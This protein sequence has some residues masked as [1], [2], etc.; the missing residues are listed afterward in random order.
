MAKDSGFKVY[1]AG[2]MRGYPLYNFPA[3]DEA[4][5]RFRALHWDVVNPAELD[6][7]IGVN[8]YTDPLPDGFLRGAMER[9]LT[10]ICGC[11]AIALLPGWERSSGVAVE[12]ALAKLLG[13][14][15]YDAATGKPYSET[16]VQEAQRLVHGDRGDSYG[17]PLDDYTKTAALWSVILGTDVTPEKAILCMVAVKVSREMHKPKRDNRV[18]ICG[19]A[20]CLQMVHDERARRAK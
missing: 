7:A 2:P 13:L 12:L 4:A 8:E 6:R 10:A 9:D 20:E 16:A 11:D 15:I 3:F 17:H 1:V 19:Y 14:A 18:D 5:A